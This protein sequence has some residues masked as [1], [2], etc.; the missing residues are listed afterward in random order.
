M[1]LQ[2]CMTFFFLWNIWTSLVLAEAQTCC[3]TQEWTSLVLAEAQTRCETRE[4]TLL[5]L[6][7]AQKCWVTRKWT[8]L[9]LNKSLGLKGVYQSEQTFPECLFWQAVLNSQHK[10]RTNVV[11]PRFF[12]FEMTSHLKW[13]LWFR[14]EYTGAFRRHP[15]M[16]ADSKIRFGKSGCFIMKTILRDSY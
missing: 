14:F 12:F 16:Q 3:V 15:P 10:L 6:D 11:L 1:S 5:V 9:V 8:S 7:E 4:W 2:N 13:L